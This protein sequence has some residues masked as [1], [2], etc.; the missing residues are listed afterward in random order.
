[1]RSLTNSRLAGSSQNNVA[2][3]LQLAADGNNEEK[4]DDEEVQLQWWG[5]HERRHSVRATALNSLEEKRW[6]AVHKF[7]DPWLSP[8]KELGGVVN[9]GIAT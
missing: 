6:F 7:P 3:T 8:D 4:V 2:H 1:M 9:T 5:D